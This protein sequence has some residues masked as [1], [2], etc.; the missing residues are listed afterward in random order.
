ML[1]SCIPAINKTHS[2][3]QD[4]GCNM[5]SSHVFRE[6]SLISLIPGN[7]LIFV[8]CHCRPICVGATSHLCWKASMW[9]QHVE[10]IGF[11]HLF[12]YC[13]KGNAV[14]LGQGLVVKPER[15]AKWQNYVSPLQRLFICAPVV[16]ADILDLCHPCLY[17]GSVTQCGL[18]F[19]LM[20]I[21]IKSLRLD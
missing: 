9:C 11:Q 10:C 19:G 16:P 15:G 20:F 2:I 14:G 18:P 13:V 8:R 1:R 17:Q 6:K 3:L 12:D 4:V 21:D 5:E 7:R